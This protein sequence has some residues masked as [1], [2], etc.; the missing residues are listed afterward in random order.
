MEKEVYF[1]ALA[2][3]QKIKDSASYREYLQYK[4]R[5]DKNPSLKEKILLFKKHQFAIEMKKMQNQP[6]DAGEEDV[7]LKEYLY[8][9]AEEDGVNYLKAER[10]ALTQINEVL[11][12][13]SEDTEFDLSI[14][15]F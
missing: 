11:S 1:Q 10:S 5:I 14:M 9:M 12:F 3:R 15:D 6:V 13:L 8:V 4:E 7:L 2:L